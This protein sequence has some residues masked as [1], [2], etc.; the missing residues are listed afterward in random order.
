MKG[1]AAW[2]TIVICIENEKGAQNS[3][4][5]VMGTHLSRREIAYEVGDVMVREIVKH[6]YRLLCLALLWGERYSSK[7]RAEIIFHWSTR[8]CLEEDSFVDDPLSHL[9]QPPVL[10][11]RVG[12]K[13]RVLHELAHRHVVLKRHTPL[14]MQL[15]IVA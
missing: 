8:P 1:A 13:A 7:R 5:L 11:M 10:D 15:L 4:W 14:G 6:E 2:A 3:S 12:E 9:A